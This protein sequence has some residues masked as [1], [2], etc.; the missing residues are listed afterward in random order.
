MSIWQI[1]RYSLAIFLQVT[2]ALFLVMAIYFTACYYIDVE[3]NLRHECI[4]GALIGLMY[5]TG[6]SIGS[7]LLA[8]T[9]KSTL[10]KREFKALTIPALILGIV[11]L[12]IY[13]GDLAYDLISST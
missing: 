9:V 6:F 5:A 10:S 1:T 13:F 4:F 3:S 11:F 12:L 7:A 8:S 2:G